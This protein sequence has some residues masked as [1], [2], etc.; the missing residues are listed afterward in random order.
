MVTIREQL[1]AEREAYA[2]T[3]RELGV[4]IRQSSPL[5]ERLRQRQAARLDK[6]ADLE[7][8][9]AAANGER[10]SPMPPVETGDA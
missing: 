3:N 8:Q 9:I 10:F 2:L 6:I 4:L 7:R 1:I 5:A